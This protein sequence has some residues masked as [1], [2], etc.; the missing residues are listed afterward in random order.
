MG[1]TSAPSWASSFE[2]TS[3]RSSLRAAATTRKP[4]RAS[5][6]VVASPMPDEAPVTMATLE[7]WNLDMVCSIAF[8]CRS[9]HQESGQE[10]DSLTR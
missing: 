10:S 8:T 2:S 4:E 7:L 1:R 3:R 6:R 9:V 5:R